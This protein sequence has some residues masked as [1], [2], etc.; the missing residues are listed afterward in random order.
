M[1]LNSTSCDFCFLF[2]ISSYAFFTLNR[3][4][5]NVIQKKWTCQHWRSVNFWCHKNSRCRNSF[6]SSVAACEFHQAKPSF[7]SSTTGRWCHSVNHWPK[8]TKTTA[9]KTAFSTFIMRRKKFSGKIEKF[10]SILSLI[11]KTIFSTP[12]RVRGTKIENYLHRV[13]EHCV[14]KYTFVYCHN[15][16]VVNKPVF[17]LLLI[18]CAKIHEIR[19]TIIETVEQS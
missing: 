4:S 2:L 7:S 12:N 17:F 14:Y 8:S 6:Q 16:R 3:S 9:A 19:P 18:I 13:I 11:N 1:R 5:L 15:Q 10:H